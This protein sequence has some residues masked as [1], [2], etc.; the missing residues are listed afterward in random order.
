MECFCFWFYNVIKY[1]V[2][3][4]IIIYVEYKFIDYKYFIIVYICMF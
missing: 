4:N 3:F 1:V 2:L